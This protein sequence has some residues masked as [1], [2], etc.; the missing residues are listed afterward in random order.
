MKYIR[1]ALTINRIKMFR[2]I[3]IA[4]TAILG[5]LLFVYLFGS[6][7]YEIKGVVF[8][9]STIPSLQGTTVIELSPFGS[10]SAPTHEIPFE[11]HLRLDYIGTDLADSIFNVENEGKNL[12]DELRDKISALLIPF[13]LRQV[14]VGAAGAFLLVILLWRPKFRYTL[15]STFAGALIIALLFAGAAKTYNIDAFREPDYDGVIALAPDFIPEPE[16]ILDKLSLVQNQTR[17]VIGNI[18][19][20][21]SSTNSLSILADPEKHGALN[22]IL[23][24][25]DLHSNPIGIAFISELA[26][27]FEV[28]FILDAGDLTDFGSEIETKVTAGLNELNVPYVFCPGNHDTPEIIEFIKSLDNAYVLD[29]NI[30]EIKGMRISGISD[31]MSSSNKVEPDNPEDWSILLQSQTDTLLSNLEKEPNIDI[32]AVHNP[33]AALNLSGFYP[34]VV[35]GHTHQQDIDIINNSTILNPGTS[36][37]AGV[38]GLYAD[39]IIPYSAMILYLKPGNPPLAVD[40][41]K[42][43][44]LSD[45]FYIERKL[46]QK[47]FK[48]E[49]PVIVENNNPQEY[50][51]TKLPME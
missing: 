19:N 37:A 51:E 13:A 46:L 11:L 22:K 38:R 41:I 49:S 50:D 20:L 32:A 9:V 10:I 1:N 2:P 23:L 36:G 29:G 12:L 31:P 33:E 45:R 27:N 4:L 16:K 34:L 44:P 8:K 40:T 18:Q 43:D 47:E 42:Y 25:S 30:I 48:N 21:M 15:L 17:K 35:Y 5:A 7:V 6:A 3:G 24:V 28:D 14:T 39:N 26:K